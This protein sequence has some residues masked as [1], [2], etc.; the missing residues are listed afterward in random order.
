MMTTP[1][2]ARTPASIAETYERDGFAL[3]ID[4][5]T[6]GDA[7]ALRD[8]L[9]AAEAELADDAERL[10]LLRTYPDR[11]LP[12]F[13]ALIRHRGILRAVTSILGPDLLVYSAAL[14]IKPARSD[15]I[16]SWHQ[17][18]TY[19]GLDDAEEVTCWVALSPATRESGCMRFVPGSHKTRIV[20]H[21]DTYADD[22][23]LSRGQEI[24]VA[25]DEADAV[26]C[27]L[28]PGQASLHHG[29][30][31]HASGPNTTEDRRIGVAI[32]YIRPS[33]KQDSGDRPLVALASGVDRFRHFSIA[34]SPQGR[35]LERD[36]KICRQEAALRRKLFL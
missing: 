25:V 6:E 13:D 3:P 22:N 4:V 30:L 29:H 7:R 27:E 35:L 8:D 18:L 14:F 34:A 1:A 32:R 21:V 24:A 11:L 17:D 31:F 9:E 33:M 26:L 2:P 20:P 36:I 28:Q 5:L 23:L 16:V 12:S 15:K 10:G 19:W